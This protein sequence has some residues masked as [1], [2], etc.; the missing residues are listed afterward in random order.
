VQHAQQHKTPAL[1]RRTNILLTVTLSSSASEQS[2]SSAGAT[3]S[4][5][6]ASGIPARVVDIASVQPRLSAAAGC[7]YG[8]HAGR[9]T[10]DSWAD[11]GLAAMQQL[12]WCAAAAAAGV[13][14]AGCAAVLPAAGSGGAAAAG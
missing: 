6:V 13:R 4:L 12:Q 3:P 8:R 1:L 10:A 11:R 14:Q 5:G 2:T 9:A 7:S